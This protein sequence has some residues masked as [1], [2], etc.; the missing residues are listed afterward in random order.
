MR[1]ERE[2]GGLT[3]GAPRDVQQGLTPN[4]RGLPPD[5]G[6]DANAAALQGL[7]ESA[8]A[9][10]GNSPTYQQDL[11]VRACAEGAGPVPAASE[12]LAGTDGGKC[13]PIAEKR[14]DTVLP[15]SSPK[16]AE[17]ANVVSPKRRMSDAAT[18]FM[19]RLAADR[20]NLEKA[21]VRLEDNEY[22][23]AHTNRKYINALAGVLSRMGKSWVFKE[24]VNIASSSNSE[25]LVFDI[26]PFFT[27]K[28]AETLQTGCLLE[29]V[30]SKS[31]WDYRLAQEGRALIRV[32]A[33][34]RD[35]AASAGKSAG[36]RTDVRAKD[37]PVADKAVAEKDAATEKPSS[38][39]GG[40]ERGGG[41]V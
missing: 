32:M 10:S 15:V 9:A 22:N 17:S 40:Q 35:A 5:T 20:R 13:V 37:A 4:G 21:C 27:D 28:D 38:D 39:K 7:P 6:A 3:Q 33:R 11:Q 31:G 29:A 24:F 25:E 1:A 41:G 2:D 12:N 14:P 26:R 36:G 8:A 16:V 19:R 18:D 30:P 23:F 34:A